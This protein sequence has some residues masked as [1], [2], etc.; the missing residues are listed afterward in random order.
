VFQYLFLQFCNSLK[1]Y[2]LFHQVRYSCP[3][4]EFLRSNVSNAY[5]FGNCSSLLLVFD[6]LIL[7][8]V[9]G[10][11]AISVVISLKFMIVSIKS[12]FVY[13]FVL[14]VLSTISNFFE[15]SIFR[16]WWFGSASCSELGF[17]SSHQSQH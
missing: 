7:L 2:W 17:S 3:F 15:R 10:P 11:V 4:P 8:L 5:G 9:I 13:F 6:P 16:S 12:F 1:I 14:I